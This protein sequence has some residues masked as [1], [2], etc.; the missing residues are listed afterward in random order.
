MSQSNYGIVEIIANIGY[1]LRTKVYVPSARMIRF[2]VVIRGKK[3]INF[4]SNL[5]IAMV[6]IQVMIKMHQRYHQIKEN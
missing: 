1:I 6:N 5:I 2:P 3:Y 4:G